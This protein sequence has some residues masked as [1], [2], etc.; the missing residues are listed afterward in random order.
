MGFFFAAAVITV[1]PA[2]FAVTFPFLETKAIFGFLDFQ[3][4][5]WEA[6]AGRTFSTQRFFDSPTYSRIS[7]RLRNSFFGMFF[8][9]AAAGRVK[10][11]KRKH[12]V[13]NRNVNF[14]VLI[15]NSSLNI[16][17]LF[18]IRCLLNLKALF[19]R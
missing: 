16:I 3:V 11:A 10:A 19:C 4:T 17:L 1:F 13:Q 7:L 9:F 14:F 18:L 2:F 15:E 6:F 5:F 8:D 12:N